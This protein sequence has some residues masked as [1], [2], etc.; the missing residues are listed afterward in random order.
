MKHSLVIEPLNYI[1]KGYETGE[2]NKMIT[3]LS[4][5]CEWSS[6]WKIDKEIG[7]NQVG[8]YYLKKGNILKRYMCFPKIS[9]ISLTGFSDR[10]SKLGL[11]MEQYLNE[12]VYDAV[13]LASISEEKQ[14]T[15]IEIKMKELYA[16]C[17]Y[18][19]IWIRF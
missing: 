11:Y 3:M 8:K 1:A 10:L 13:I 15:R 17:K 19:P 5:N 7:S 14:I 9:F 16:I 6:D 18:D 4:N 2:F 12:R